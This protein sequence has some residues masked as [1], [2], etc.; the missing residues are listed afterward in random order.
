MFS[1]IY[2]G[3]HAYALELCAYGFE[4]AVK[5]NSARYV[6]EAYATHQMV[7][8]FW[9]PLCVMAEAAET[10]FV[11]D[12]DGGYYLDDEPLAEVVVRLANDAAFFYHVRTWDEMVEYFKC[13]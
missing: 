3:P 7:K 1:I 5:S 10:T 2:D 11:Q 9:E 6:E 12:E 13:R 4:S 8:Y